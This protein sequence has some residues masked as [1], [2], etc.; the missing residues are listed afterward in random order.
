MNSGDLDKLSSLLKQARAK[1]QLNSTTRL[2][3]KTLAESA[4]TEAGKANKPQAALIKKIEK[5]GN[6]ITT[7]DGDVIALTAL[8]GK[9]IQYWQGKNNPILGTYDVDASNLTT[10]AGVIARQHYLVSI[11]A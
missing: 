3:T 10:I 4:T 6:E 2:V 7:V 9:R 8:L 5:L 11:Y 1:G